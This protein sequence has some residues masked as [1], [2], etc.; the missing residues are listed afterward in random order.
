MPPD[1][2]NGIIQGYA[3]KY[4]S[5]ING[6]STLITLGEYDFSYVLKSLNKATA[7]EIRLWAFT[8]VGPGSI[9]SYSA[10]T[11]EDGKR[12]APIYLLSLFIFSVRQWKC[13]A[14]V[15]FLRARLLSQFGQYDFVFA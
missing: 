1:H 4:W 15:F 13:V 9:A 14:F 5:A 11:K 10:M 7:Y 3:V 6:T 12:C 8:R 2:R